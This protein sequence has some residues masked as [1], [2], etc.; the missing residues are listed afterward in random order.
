MAGIKGRSGRR[1]KNA[2]AQ[3]A[4]IIDK[5]WNVF[6]EAMYDQSLTLKEKAELAVKVVAKNMP[7]KLEGN[8]TYNQMNVLQLGDR[9]MRYNLGN[10]PENGMRDGIIESSGDTSNPTEIN[11]DSEIA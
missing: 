1:C 11:A 2:E 4:K 9:L 7:A 5:A 3:R 6:L 8:L 10:V